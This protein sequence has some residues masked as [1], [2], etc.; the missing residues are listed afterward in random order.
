MRV[1]RTIA[2]IACVGGALLAGLAAPAQA[3]PTG[4]SVVV[5]RTSSFQFGVYYT[6]WAC[7][8]F[9]N[10]LVQG[11]AFSSYAC[12]YEWRSGEPQGYWY[13]YVW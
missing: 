12:Y 5:T 6:Q 2:A 11:G 10:S 8:Y 1:A 9:G 7:Q 3:A 13:L 4:P